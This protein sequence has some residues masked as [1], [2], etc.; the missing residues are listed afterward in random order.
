MFNAQSPNQKKAQEYEL[1]P[2]K[3]LLA[4]IGFS[5]AIDMD[6]LCTAILCRFNDC[7]LFGL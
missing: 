1:V 5:D 4:R 3:D 6:T 7:I 2:C